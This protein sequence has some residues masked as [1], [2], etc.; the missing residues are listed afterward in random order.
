MPVEKKKI[1]SHKDLVVWQ[2]SYLLAKQIYLM[3][4]KL[5]SA[6]NFGLVSQI[7]RSAVSVPSNIAE[8]FGRKSNKSFKQFLLIAYGSLA[9]LDTQISLAKDIY[10]VPIES[11]SLLIEEVRKMLSML[12][13]K[14]D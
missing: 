8:G 11:E 1:Q 7:Q 10:T 13:K 3:T 9:E 14:L 6:E 12:I 4:K 2:K 5:P